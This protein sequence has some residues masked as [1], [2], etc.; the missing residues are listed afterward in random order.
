MTTQT[1]RRAPERRTR[2][3]SIELM[4]TYGQ[5][6]SAII[7]VFALFVTAGVALIGLYAFVAA[8]S[9]PTADVFD[10][11]RE[12]S[13]LLQ[14]EAWT[15]VGGEVVSWRDVLLV[16][17][18]LAALALLALVSSALGTL[19]H[20]ER[21]RMVAAQRT[22]SML[23]GA[24]YALL[25][26]FLSIPCIALAAGY[27]SGQRLTVFLLGFLILWILLLLSGQPFGA[28]LRF[29]IR[30]HLH[31]LVLIIAGVAA[32]L[33]LLTGALDGSSVL[34]LVAVA[35]VMELF[36]TAMRSAARKSPRKAP[37]AAQSQPR[38]T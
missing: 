23:F 17:I 1:H 35:A 21:G 10:F 38:E 25:A 30:R 28:S 37:S 16:Q 31:S 36:M 26:V 2:R 19:L 18:A 11:G 7:G 34:V 3:A 22:H 20:A 24:A 14:A 6:V 33:S 4:S 32:C 27:A 12:F 15:R 5:S 13:R 9:S 29:G 8:A